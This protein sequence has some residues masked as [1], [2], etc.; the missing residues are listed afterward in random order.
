MSED[1]LQKLFQVILERKSNPSENSYTA[2]LFSKGIDKILK[3]FGE[4]AVEV[5]IAGKGGVREEII[6]ESADLL[7]HLF[8][9]L[10]QHNISLDD[11]K[12]EL[13]RRSGV[14]GIE[15]KASRKA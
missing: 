8:V 12:I 7:Y 4:E 1:S 9:L 13:E 10:A 3:K 2:S 14:S 11:V 15:E 5:V 6:Y